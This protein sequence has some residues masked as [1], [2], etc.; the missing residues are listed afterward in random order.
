MSCIKVIIFE[1]EQQLRDTRR[2]QRRLG[3]SVRGLQLQARCRWEA[4]LGSVRELNPCTVHHP[5]LHRMVH[6][7]VHHIVP[8]HRMVHHMV[9]VSA[10]NEAQR[11]HE[12]WGQVAARLLGLRHLHLLSLLLVVVVS[13]G[14]NHCLADSTS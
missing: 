5:R 8:R 6:Y 11:M 7:M 14:R 9:R 3:A 13:S 1:A 2:P 4:V 10:L 12:Q